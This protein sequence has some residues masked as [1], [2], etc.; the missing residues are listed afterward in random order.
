MQAVISPTG[1][2]CSMLCTP[3]GKAPSQTCCLERPMP[4]AYDPMGGQAQVLHAGRRHPKWPRQGFI[5]LRRWTPARRDR[6]PPPPLT[7]C[8]DLGEA[9]HLQRHDGGGAGHGWY[10]A[11]G[12]RGLGVD[13]RTARIGHG[14]W[15]SHPLYF[16]QGVEAMEYVRTPAL[17]V[18][19]TNN[20]APGM[21]ERHTTTHRNVRSATYYIL[22]AWQDDFPVD[23]LL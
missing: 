18:A 5:S 13:P 8:E 6:G 15:T 16:R 20:L 14:C 3:P 4:L 21:M 2:G 23:G 7:V 17:L 12:F 19:S 9:Q 10:V 11:C 22:S 1:A